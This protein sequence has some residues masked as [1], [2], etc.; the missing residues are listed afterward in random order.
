M[1]ERRA[2]LHLAR[3]AKRPPTRPQLTLPPRQG[4]SGSVPASVVVSN[5]GWG[6]TR[7]RGAAICPPFTVCSRSRVAVPGRPAMPIET[8]RRG[9]VAY[10]AAAC[11][12]DSLGEVLHRLAG[13]HAA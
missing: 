12:E 6:E 3:T 7:V 1:R 10:L 8:Q 4:P 5:V 11:L 9:V 2:Q 13:M